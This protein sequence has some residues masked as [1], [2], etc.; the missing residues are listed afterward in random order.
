MSSLQ[1]VGEREGGEMAAAKFGAAERK[2]DALDH[3]A[4]CSLQIVRRL[5]IFATVRLPCA[6]TT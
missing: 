6:S 1:C 2:D 5:L 3:P 4:L